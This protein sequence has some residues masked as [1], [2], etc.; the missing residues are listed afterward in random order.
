LTID[1]LLCCVLRHDSSIAGAESGIET[2]SSMQPQSVNDSEP[3]Q[4][5][6]DVDEIEEVIVGP[7]RKLHLLF[8]MNSRG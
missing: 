6:D 1:I 3:I 5:D 4:I 7:K 2:E 8:G